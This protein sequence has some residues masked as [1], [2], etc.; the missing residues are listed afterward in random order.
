MTQEEYILLIMDGLK[1]T[2]R[3]DISTGVD[4]PIIE[5]LD[6]AIDNL[7][8]HYQVD[9]KWSRFKAW[10]LE[11]RNEIMSLW[12][13]MKPELIDAIEQ[14]TKVCRNRKLTK[15]IKSASAYAMIKSAMREADLKFQYNG[16]THRAKVSVLITSNRAITLYIPYKRINEYLPQVMESLNL[17]KKGMETLDN[18]TTIDRAYN[19]GQWE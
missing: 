18:N 9:K 8:R 5:Y 1:P 3:Q 11:N 14:Y 2:I 13:K 10:T 4:R 17:I 6:Q 19:T 7:K 12:L 15:E 16:Q